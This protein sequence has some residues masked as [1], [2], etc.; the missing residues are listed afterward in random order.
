[1]S[2]PNAVFEALFVYFHCVNE[3]A[4]HVKIDRKSLIIPPQTNFVGGVL[5]SACGAVG[6]SAKSCPDNS[7][8]SF[9][10]ISLILGRSVH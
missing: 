5:E 4:A 8:Y 10:P 1:M 3:R 2:S 7:S 9:S 6:L